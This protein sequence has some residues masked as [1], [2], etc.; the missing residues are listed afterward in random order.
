[1]A[2][3]TSISNDEYTLLQII[4]PENGNRTP[5]DI[6][7]IIDVSG[8]MGAEAKIKS[9]SGDDEGYGFNRLDI[10]KHS[11]LTIIE[12]LNEKDKLALISFS[13]DQITEMELTNMDVNN[14]N[15]AKDILKNIGLRGSTNLW[16]GLEA[17]METMRSHSSIDRN[18]SIFLL[19][20]GEPTDIP[21]NGE[22]WQLKNYIEK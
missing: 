4:P 11:I 5:S 14:K 2:N 7:A 21:E 6:C 18:P 3:I 1:M 13:N 16:G 15:K 10:V 12:S 19:T 9:T 20:D 22:V 17:G 8:S